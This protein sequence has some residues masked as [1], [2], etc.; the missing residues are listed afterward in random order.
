MTALR[1][2]DVIPGRLTGESAGGFV[3][4]LPE[5]TAFLPDG[6]DARRLWEGGEEPDRGRAFFQV[7]EAGTA[8][9]P[10]VLAPW[11]APFDH[12]SI[13]E[14]RWGIVRATLSERVN[15]V[16]LG[17]I[18]G[19]LRLDLSSGPKLLTPGQFI[20]VLVLDIDRGSERITL[21]LSREA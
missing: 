10:A 19:L 8:D 14:V 4:G 16:D 20:R 7:V 18:D 11:T 3:V 9:R 15:F 2:G 21:V 6:P 13:G 1:V 12:F 5:G 17:G